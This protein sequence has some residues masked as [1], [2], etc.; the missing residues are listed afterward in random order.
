MLNTPSWTKTASV[1]FQGDA[2]R[3]L[4]TTR[5]ARRQRQERWASTSPVLV[6][7]S[8]GGLDAKLKAATELSNA[9]SGEADRRITSGGPS[10]K[11]SDMVK[12]FEG[13]EESVIIERGDGVLRI[14][15]LPV[16]ATGLDFPLASPLAAAP[17]EDDVNESASPSQP[18]VPTDHEPLQDMPAPLS[19]SLPSPESLECSTTANSSTPPTEAAEAAHRSTRRPARGTGRTSSCT[20]ARSVKPTGRSGRESEL[21]LNRATTQRR[22]REVPVVSI[23]LRA[24]RGAGCAGAGFRFQPP[25]A[26]TAIATAT[27][28]PQAASLDATELE[29]PEPL[30]WEQRSQG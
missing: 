21:P 8:K 16:S 3:S 9:L 30:V 22:G 5:A 14:F 6:A 28:E 11:I 27:P 19:P 13:R 17:C 15:S 18:L 20:A 23:V 1:P 29:V 26:A 4:H 24:N 2:S 10:R 25:K 7:S 12:Y